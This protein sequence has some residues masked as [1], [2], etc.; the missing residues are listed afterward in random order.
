[1]SKSRTQEYIHHPTCVVVLRCT[2]DDS[3][4]AADEDE[5]EGQI[6]SSGDSHI[7]WH[8]DVYTAAPRELRTKHIEVRRLPTRIESRAC[9]QS[10]D[11]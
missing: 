8:S 10:Y 6:V 5:D 4:G 11:C 3:S 1:M 9:H 2:V 7:C